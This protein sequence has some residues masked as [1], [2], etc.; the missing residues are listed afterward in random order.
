ME[1][2]ELVSIITPV[3]NAD[4]TL[5]RCVDSILAQKYDKW[6]LILVD[7]GSKDNSGFICDLYAQE[8]PTQIIVVHKSNGGVSSARNIGLQH[9]KGQYVTFIDSDDYV[10]ESYISDFLSVNADLVV[11]G[12]HY[13]FTDLHILPFR[14]DKAFYCFKNDFSTK[15]LLTLPM[16][17]PWAKLFKLDIIRNNSIRFDENM[18]FAEDNVFV[19][20]YLACC[21]SMFYLESSPY[22]YYCIGDGVGSSK[23]P[24]NFAGCQYGLHRMY[25]ALLK[26]SQNIKKDFQFYID[27]KVK[28]YFRFLMAYE[29]KNEMSF[30]GYLSYKNNIKQMC[31]I[32]LPNPAKQGAFLK[33]LFY[34]LKW[35]CY[36]ASYI[37][38]HT[39][40]GKKIK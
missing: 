4:K 40:Y 23:Y 11:C 32:S 2:D 15:E 27:D 31:S 29:Y 30:S 24:L 34:L 10:A 26:C 17:A 18:R 16:M 3:Y 12:M 9:A 33:L 37:V 7:D 22:Y 36:L 25:Q 1:R 13:V 8:H 5:K 6:E 21:S 35:R 19:L 38:I 28:M 20:E 39:V 14:F